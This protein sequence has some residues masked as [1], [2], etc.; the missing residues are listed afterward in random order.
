MFLRKK[1]QND[2]YKNKYFKDIKILYYL[3]FVLFILL[4]LSGIPQ[5]LIQQGV[6]LFRYE[7]LLISLAMWVLCSLVD[8]PKYFNFYNMLPCVAFGYGAMWFV[9]EILSKVL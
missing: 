5:V 9:I 4:M 8:K 2:N 3:G 7:A 6:S 1:I